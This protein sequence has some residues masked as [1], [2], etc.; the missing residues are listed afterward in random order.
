[1]PDEPP[2]RINHKSI[3]ARL[4]KTIN[5]HANAFPHLSLKIT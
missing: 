1:V 5:L 2:S 4:F 3:S